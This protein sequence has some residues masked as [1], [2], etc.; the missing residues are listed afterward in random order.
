VGEEQKNSVKGVF[1]A[2]SNDPDAL[3]Y[4]GELVK[5][6]QNDCITVCLFKGRCAA[7]HQ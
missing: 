3:Q 4:A 5:G 1:L 2:I 7:V 6:R